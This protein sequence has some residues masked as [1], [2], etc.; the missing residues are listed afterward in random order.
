MRQAIMRP[1]E[2][3]KCVHADFAIEQDTEIDRLRAEVVNVRAIM[4]ACVESNQTLDADLAAA[5]ARAAKGPS[6]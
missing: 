4:N 5:I 3:F 1:S 6:L 2:D